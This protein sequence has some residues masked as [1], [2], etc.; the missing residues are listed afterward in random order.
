MKKQQG[1]KYRKK[2][3]HK[4]RQ[5]IYLKRL[6]IAVFGDA[7]VGKTSLIKSFCDNT[8]TDEYE[9]TIEDFF[10]KHLL[11][12]DRTYQI[13]IID[14][15]GSENF[16]AMRKVDME[17]ADA[18]ILVYSP[19]KNRSFEQISQYRD[20][21]LE[22]KGITTPVVVV[23][24]KRDLS[25]D[26]SSLYAIDK[27]GSLVNTQD[28]AQKRWRY[29]WTNTSAKMGCSTSEPFLMLLDEIQRRKEET[30]NINVSPNFK[31]KTSWLNRNFGS[32]LSLKRT[33]ST[34][35]EKSCAH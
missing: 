10:T 14:T 24:N 31:R 23:A 13:D 34:G 35:Q 22:Q 12:N 11:H 1:S 21:I 19:D 6:T 26:S 27:N 7:G 33:K 25:L 17:K 29:M 9:P 28:I 2:S 32:A 30:E 3:A 15:C 5:S 8:F 4:R 20:E 16:P 18:I